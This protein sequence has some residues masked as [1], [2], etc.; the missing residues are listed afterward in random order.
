MEEKNNWHDLYFNKFDIVNTDNNHN[1]NDFNVS[2][3]LHLFQKIESENQ[4]L[5]IEKEYFES[6]NRIEELYKKDNLDLYLKE[7]NSKELLKEELDIIRLLSK[8]TLQNNY[9]DYD[10]FIKSIKLIFKISE[11]LRERINQESIIHKN[12]NF[13]S[14]IPRCSYKFC[15]FKDNCYYNYNLKNKNV[16]Y[17]DHFVHNMVSADLVI[18]EE[19]INF[20]FDD[21]N[22]ITPN[23]EILKTINTLSFVI[24]HMQHELNSKCLYLNDDECEKMHFVK[25]INSK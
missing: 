20:K 14:Y 10:F 15:S 25:K 13:N 19:Y 5:E 4:V 11:I 22:I 1:V 3:F 17:Q 24:S 16:C 8:Y 21:K 2:K 7:K 12:K 23:K 9:I 6:L 18:L